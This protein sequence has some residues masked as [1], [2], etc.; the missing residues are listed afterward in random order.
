MTAG[1]EEREHESRSLPGKR[2]KKKNEKEG[3]GIP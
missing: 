2:R 3:R 1:R